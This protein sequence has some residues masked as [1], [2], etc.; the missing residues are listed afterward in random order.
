VKVSGSTPNVLQQWIPDLE[1]K[2]GL[3]QGHLHGHPQ[4]FIASLELMRGQL[5]GMNLARRSLEEFFVEQVGDRN[6]NNS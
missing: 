2:D 5:V 3:W 1:F 4:D 6:Q